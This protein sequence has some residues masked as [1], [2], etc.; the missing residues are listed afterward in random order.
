M[1]GL[2][3]EKKNDRYHHIEI[4]MVTTDAELVNLIRVFPIPSLNNDE[5][6]LYAICVFLPNNGRSSI[7]STIIFGENSSCQHSTKWSKGDVH[8]LPSLTPEIKYIIL[9]ALF[10]HENLEFFIKKIAHKISEEIGAVA[11]KPSISK[12]SFSMI[13]F[14][15]IMNSRKFRRNQL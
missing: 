5:D 3:I 14:E 15:K 11:L 8:L 6:I 7:V 4:D 9:H 10:H 12:R 13:E 1:R 2:L